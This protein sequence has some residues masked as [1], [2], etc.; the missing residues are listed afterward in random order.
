MRGVMILGWERRNSPIV[1]SSV[2]PCTPCPVV[3][4]SIVLEPYMT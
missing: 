3:Y 2:N 4:T 1:G